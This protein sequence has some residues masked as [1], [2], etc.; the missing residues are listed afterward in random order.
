MGSSDEVLLERY[1]W[2]PSEELECSCQARSNE[3][4]LPQV[5]MEAES[6]T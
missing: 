6:G 2:K 4:P 5:S 3:E 1:Q